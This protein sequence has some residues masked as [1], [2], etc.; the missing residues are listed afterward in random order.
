M[1]F[2]YFTALLIVKNISVAPP[3]TNFAV[4][5]TRIT[6]TKMQ[7]SS[8]AIVPCAFADIHDFS[9]GINVTIV[10]ENMYVQA[11]NMTSVI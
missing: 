4:P 5:F 7:I 9:D 2:L 6:V 1:I 10:R 8:Q 11:D 3:Y